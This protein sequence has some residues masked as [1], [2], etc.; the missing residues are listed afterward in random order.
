MNRPTP[1]LEERCSDAPKYSGSNKLTVTANQDL[2]YSG[3]KNFRN[4]A[5]EGQLLLCGIWGVRNSCT[6]ESTGALAMNGVMVVGRN[7][8]SS[9]LNVQENAT[10]TVEGE[11][12]IFGD[13]TLAENAKLEF[14][15]DSSAIYV[16]GNVHK[17]ATATVIGTFSD[18]FSK[19]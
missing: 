11:L 5:I 7:N 13:L 18:P 15:G 19:F 16:Y 1:T 2:A 17:A 3:R 8:R 14:L 9:N 6:I 4:L 12:V 10:L